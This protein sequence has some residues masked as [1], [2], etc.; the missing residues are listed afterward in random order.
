[1][2][3]C[4]YAIVTHQ[5]PT[6]YQLLEGILIVIPALFANSQLTAGNLMAYMIY[7]PAH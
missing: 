4:K 3:Q 7:F 1:M 6:G 5:L 2:A